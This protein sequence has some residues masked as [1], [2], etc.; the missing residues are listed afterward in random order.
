MQLGHRNVKQEVER[1]A[2]VGKTRAGA[3]IE[4]YV[5]TLLLQCIRVI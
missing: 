4:D 5:K 1:L 3:V 2:M